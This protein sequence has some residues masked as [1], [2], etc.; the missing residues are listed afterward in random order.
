MSDF[1]RYQE[2]M[3][4]W[5]YGLL[6]AQ[7]TAELEAFLATAP[8]GEPLRRQALEWQRK[9]AAAA[10]AEFP[11]LQFAPPTAKPAARPMPAKA[12]AK[13]KPAARSV[14]RRWTRWAIAVSTLLVVCGFG[15]PATVKYVNHVK[16]AGEVRE[17]QA[18]LEKAERERNSFVAVYNARRD[19]AARDEKQAEQIKQQA[20][21][22]NGELLKQFDA[23]L[24][25]ARK[26]IEEKQFIVRLSGPERAQPGAPNEWQ[27]EM[28]KRNGAI[29]M[30]SKIEWSVKD[31]TGKVVWS[32]TKVAHRRDGFRECPIS[33]P[34]AFW[35][36]VKPDSELTLEVTA[37]D[38]NLK[39]EVSA[40]VPLARPIF[41]THLATDKPLYKPGEAVFFRSLTLDRATFLPP[42]K[43]LQLEFRIT[44]PGGQP[45]PIVLDGMPLRGS[46]T[47]YTN[48]GPLLGPDKKPLRGIGCG[49]Y[50]LP[51]DA[52]GGEYVLSVVDVTPS[53]DEVR[54]QIVNKN[55]VLQTRKFNVIEYKPETFEKT[56][57]FDGKSYGPGDVVMVKCTA[58]RTQ[59]GKLKRAA[60][61]ATAEVEGKPV[62][63]IS[64]GKTDDEGVVR[65]KLTLPKD[66]TKGTGS[67]TVR[68]ADGNDSEP[69]Y[70]PIP[71]VGRVI[72]VEF[73]PEG[74]DLVENVPCRVYFQATT[75]AGRPADLK[76]HITDGIETV[77][78]IATLTDAD[79]AGVSR[80]Q[81]VFTITPKPGKKYFL[82]V[83]KPLNILEPIV[84]LPASANSVASAVAA[85]NFAA[86]TTTV[87]TGFELPKAKDDGVVLTSTDAVTRPDQPIRVQL[88]T[89]KAKRILVVGAY[90]RGRLV[91][92]QRT[93]VE[94]GQPAELKLNPNS[95]AGGVTRLT[96]FEEKVDR[97]S[98]TLPL[99]PVAERLV[100]RRPA[101]QL[102][103]NVNPDK[104]RYN[105]ASRVGL[106]V[107]AYN[108]S[109][110]AVP[111]IVMV[112]VVNQSVLTMADE[113]TGRLMPTHFLLA[114]EVN[115]PE[116]LEHADFLLYDPEQDRAPDMKSAIHA[117]KAAQALDLLLGT[118]GWRRFAEQH[119][120]QPDPKY[121]E[122]VE[123]M[124]VANGQ[125]SQTPI[126]TFRQ[127]E[128]RV[129]SEFQPKI[130]ASLA[131]IEAA[132]T[133]LETA[134]TENA[135]VQGEFGQIRTEERRLASNQATAYQ[136]YEIALKE[137]RR[138]END[139]A[140][141]R[142]FLFAGLCIGLL[143]I[144]GASLVVAT[145]RTGREKAPYFATALGTLAL[146]AVAVVGGIMMGRTDATGR[147]L[148][149]NSL[150]TPDGVA[151]LNQDED[152]RHAGM[153]APAMADAAMPK[154]A[155]DP[156]AK[157][158]LGGG[159]F[160]KP[161]RGGGFGGGGVGFPPPPGPAGLGGPLPTAPT[162]APPGL[163]PGG[164][165]GG[166]GFGPPKADRDE[167]MMMEKAKDP[168]WMKGEDKAVDGKVAVNG[169]Q[170]YQKGR[171]A[172]ANKYADRAKILEEQM[173]RNHMRKVT[174]GPVPSAV[175]G[176]NFAQ[177]MPP[178]F[179][180]ELALQMAQLEQAPGFY[181]REFK[182]DKKDSNTRDNFAE[183]VYWNPVLVLPDSGRTEIN[184]Q[185]SDSISRYQVLV[186]GHTLDGRIGATT[187]MIEA[188]KPFTVDPKTPIE[189]T[190]NDR[191]DIPIRV[192][193][194]SDVRRAVTFTVTPDG[195]K[196][197]DSS[198]K[199][200]DGKYQDWI[201][202][203]ANQKGRTIVSYRPTKKQ[204][205]IGLTVVGTSDP[206][207]AAD[208]IVRNFRV[209]PE[210]FPVSGAVS[211]LLEKRAFANFELPKDYLPGTLKVQVHV[212]PTTL[213][214]LQAGLE[215]LLR[216]PCGCF[217][218]TSTSNYPNLLIL[219]YLKSSDQA[220]PELAQRAK[221]LLDRGYSKLVSFE[222]PKSDTN[223]KRGFE[224]FGA[225]DQQH[226]ALT[227]Y[228][229]LQF[230]DLAKVFKVDPELIKRTQQ[231]LLAQRDGKGGFNRNAR[232]IDT[233]GR[234]PDHLTNAYIVWALVESDPDDK[235]GMDLTKELGA[236][237]KQAN[238]LAE[239][240]DDPYFLALVAN[241]LLHRPAGGNREEGV[242]IL[243]RIA[244]KHLKNGSVEGA[245]TSIT[246]S[247]GRD[248]QI[249]TT[250]LAVMG[251]LRC[252]EP[253]KFIK[254][255]KE[256][257]KWIGQQRGGYG[258][259]GSTQSTIL[260][261]KALIE[262]TK[263]SR[264]PAENGEYTLTINGKKFT[265]TFTAK[266][267]EVITLDFDKPDEVFKPGKNEAELTIT[268]KES[269]PFSLAWSC[270]TLTPLSSD[271]CAVEVATKLDRKNAVEG[272]TV[273]LDVSLRNKLD[274]GH[275]MAV[276]IVGLPGG[277]RLPADLK[278]LTKL[279]EEGVISYFEVRGRELILYWRSLKPEQKIELSVG[280][281]CEV[282]GEF[283]GPASRGYLYYNADHKH[284]VE[285]V[286]LTIAPSNQPGNDDVGGK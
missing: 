60:V 217:E 62:E 127:E 138:F 181:V 151:F 18:D 73:F 282:P 96:V 15:I 103:I 14:D 250:A 85:G 257:T 11:N 89:G 139:G 187:T 283:R 97:D 108:E 24:A 116:D 255:V 260:A 23:A 104:N 272:E 277:C 118:Q 90:A 192:V 256:A 17:R 3:L 37:H 220:K 270:N 206:I 147:E 91:D 263:A 173:R 123:R 251:W 230:K 130:E 179:E 31:Q 114:S 234:A 218:Q 188:R 145:R 221:E 59:G 4:D 142:A 45:E 84:S 49:L 107:R 209:V 8:E 184:F 200:I 110:K 46:A 281:I 20:E 98:K 66:I 175:G 158:D 47:N 186:A 203:A 16:Q 67:I 189:I 193:N 253:T 125:K 146:C 5:I 286:G 236:L 2:M 48:A 232:A 64:P 140:Q 278:E 126:E 222:C 168:R 213:A 129:K 100:Y 150:R 10:K 153:I 143:V 135:R 211:D 55:I 225:R 262:H 154:E 247:G 199:L 77:T 35:E 34:V 30:P 231:Y 58:S 204:G 208:N 61:G 275:G 7:Q 238:D 121:K 178:M 122:E 163:R 86:L 174:G 259:F 50:E 95:T 157:M 160:T 26:A 180:R 223:D 101:E 13:S 22:E 210:G 185:L 57:E 229:L 156:A 56:L 115:K 87:S 235:E 99:V 159:A 53:V 82:K 279:R 177:A 280:L 196:L 63:V 72:N 124:L 51:P 70:R 28:Y 276:A 27:V 207:D 131:K 172:A 83:T 239:A 113:K 39:S 224:W 191:L 144:G 136:K 43:D 65:L 105:P 80:G 71:I 9:L 32:E 249:E 165:A 195:L 285:P 216:E 75:P 119:L 40:K 205:E 240:K 149:R 79:E 198:A 120:R 273:K 284:W 241:A 148:T 38:S 36:K 106:D 226:Q 102:I 161:L 271:K 133:V 137:L 25:S 155:A 134:R 266:D 227:A 212:Y 268:T 78:Q 42:A 6:D 254:P 69:I 92:H 190:S 68:F 166:R 171:M 170:Q 245:R 41:V 164:G 112:A 265:K 88:Q 228:G 214:D 183:T 269:Y 12:A 176:P 169:I 244:E 194:D 109:E 94:P 246:M 167:N 132:A 33:L 197:D 111:A 76:G 19:Q 201:E 243:G 274:K 182:F 128:E 264:K 54:K 93:E 237:K 261:L 252:G 21:D 141:S 29:A 152:Q 74:G 1:E 202:L 215:G 242:A 162:A 258:G 248:L 44:K 267:S 233:F 219:D 117:A 52:P 81:G